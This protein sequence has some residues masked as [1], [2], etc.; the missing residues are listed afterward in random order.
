MAD[1][2]SKAQTFK[3]R[4]R[5]SPVQSQFWFSEQYMNDP[6]QSNMA[7]TYK[8]SG[9]FQV[10]QFRMALE[11]VLARHESLQTAFFMD[12]DTGKL[13][14]AVRCE[15]LP[16][17]E[18]IED[19]DEVSYV[20]EFEKAKEKTWRLDQGEVFRV[21]VLN[22]GTGDYKILFY[23]H[24]LAVDAYS[25]SIFLKELNLA[26]QGKELPPMPP[27]YTEYSEAQHR[28]IETGEFNRQF[29]YWRQNLT[30]L[31]E[32]SPLLPFARVKA[33]AATRDFQSHIT[34]TEINPRCTERVKALS[35]SL[36]GSPFHFHL[37]VIHILL[38]RLLGTDEVCIGTTDAG[39]SDF[40]F[41][42]TVGFFVNTLPLRL[43]AE[44]GDNFTTL[45]R[46]TAG[47]AVSA[48]SNSAVPFGYILDQLN[49]PR[50]SQ[51]TPIFQIMVN[52]RM[53]EVM[54]LPMGDAYLKYVDAVQARS[55]YDMTINITPSATRPW[56]LEVVCRNYL[57]SPE[58]AQ[59]FTD[60][61][62]HL[63]QQICDDPTLSVE[64]YS[65]FPT[66]LIND[67]LR[68][69]EGEIQEH[70]WPE[71]LVERFDNIAREHAEA[72]AV[73]D[74][75]GPHSYADLASLINGIAGA[76]LETGIEVEA[77][78]AVLCEPSLQAI[79]AMLA[80]L[81]VGAVYVPVDIGLP[82]E[83]QTSIL[84]D[85]KP[86]VL[87]CQATT[88]GTAKILTGDG[89]YII[90]TDSL[91]T[92]QSTAPAPNRGEPTSLA[93][94]LYSSG[95]TG[96]PKGIMLPQAMFRNWIPAQAQTFKYRPETVL[97]QSSLGFDMSIAQM[98]LA[99][100]FGG[101]LVIVP[102]NLRFDPIGI[103]R[104]MVSERVTLTFGTPA[105]YTM[106]LRYGI[107]YLTLLRSW[108]FV[109]VGGELVT[110]H[111]ISEFHQRLSCYCPNITIA[112][113]PTEAGGV[114]CT[115][116]LSGKEE[117]IMEGN[118]GK[119]FPNTSLYIVDDN[120]SLL[121][122][123]FPGEICIAGGGVGLGYLDATMAEGKFLNNPFASAEYR[124][125]GWTKLYRTGDK[126]KLLE[127]GSLLFMSRLAGETVLK[128]R[129]IRVDLE[130]VSHALLEAA[131]DLISHAIVSA[132]GQGESRFLVA[133]VVLAPGKAASHVE[134]QTIA[135]N[136]PLPQAI[137][138]SII[139]PVDTIPTTPNGKV[140]R[141]AV[142]A[143]PLP[144]TNAAS[145]ADQSFTLAE[146]ELKMHWE[147]VLYQTAP[148]M[149][150]YP[151]SDFF[152]VGGTSILLAKLQGTLRQ[153]TGITIP[154]AELFKSS[155]LNKMATMLSSKKSEIMD[156]T[157][158][159]DEETKVPDHFVQYRRHQPGPCRPPIVR[160]VLLTGCTSFI[161]KA[162]L[163]TLLDTPTITKVHCIAVAPEQSSSLPS[164]DRV[165]IYTGHLTDPLLGIP[166]ANFST[167]HSTID[168]IVHAGTFGN[169][170]NRY[171]SLR[172]PNFHS[173][174]F[175][176]EFAARAHIPLH[177]ISSNRVTLL[178]GKTSYP[179]ISVSSYQ[180]ATDGS[181]GFVAAKWASEKFLESVSKEIGLN[182][183]I[184]RPC[185]V[186]GE[187]APSTDTVNAVIH[188][189]RVLM[190]VPALEGMDG[191]FDFREV[192]EV[193][194]G[195]VQTILASGSGEEKL[196]YKHHSSGVKVPIRELGAHLAKLY[197][198]EYGKVS[199]QEWLRLAGEA[200]MEVIVGKFM[201]AVIE[202]GIARSFPFLEDEDKA[203]EV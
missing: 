136:L 27:S 21:T 13:V 53:G 106:L 182:V 103:S 7:V 62:S 55:P 76:L 98:F 17:F 200:G 117:S 38:C 133:H 42:N 50:S 176:A 165:I 202:T 15:P 2:T 177:Y 28:A 164:S 168:L 159:W 99:L 67:A 140:D 161:G 173:T 113:G 199:T 32:V 151:K 189:S 131:P 43:R 153:S 33:R 19:A 158:N 24:H 16:Y 75:S 85:C 79:A 51:H 156:D 145:K 170:M 63:L 48:L 36:R 122:P 150:I 74:A 178:S 111:L 102:Q 41:S 184:H 172:V 82:V 119:V 56:M 114:V 203:S 40:R 37:S 34:T 130:E 89:I 60:I 157:I 71:T 58:S 108:R 81:R 70:Q 46:R 12:H 194:D 35:R 160:E 152:A 137:R 78:I 104:L 88:M 148:A 175:L 134:L 144:E 9:N 73:T 132:R 44:Q 107:E 8:T 191:Y 5:M 120:V 64:R 190:T 4:H 166:K 45:F 90:N 147:E 179:P 10:P 192:A 128:L 169:C 116:P 115:R 143:L 125:R 118:V 183:C 105:E 3:R 39:R 54:N 126:G 163:T 141:K 146:A 96:K 198:G 185:Y 29:K 69:G 121:P 92:S 109:Y 174:I 171:S 49:I 68:L 1:T 91:D 167:L 180:P 20:K 30:P 52:Y 139:V 77:R 110:D 186:I 138:P 154:L 31:P 18:Y 100:G 195:I 188:F 61:Y 127:D 25:W 66:T 135:A 57:Y 196:R 14:Q 129:G 162:I 80:A 84:A 201:E 87:V 101:T 47:T 23:F 187:D 22:I 94:I 93:F 97:Q 86:A 6:T 142:A 193:A 59:R 11:Q 123:G 26:C 83:R 65:L 181:E 197:R 149:P 112:Y 72:V 155:T 95:S 124:S